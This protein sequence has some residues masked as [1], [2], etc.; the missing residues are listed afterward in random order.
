MPAHGIKYQ[1]E[2]GNYVWTRHRT[3]S[4]AALPSNHMKFEKI[5]S[6]M[7][8][9]KV[10]DSA[11]RCSRMEKGLRCTRAGALLSYIMHIA[12]CSRAH[13][14]WKG[15]DCEGIAKQRKACRTSDQR[16]QRDESVRYHGTKTI[17]R[18]NVDRMKA[19]LI[20]HQMIRSTRASRWEKEALV[21]RR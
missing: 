17:T 2:R 5:G 9:S 13:Y 19:Q 11:G 16:A 4:A 14:T 12:D 18:L 7:K 20:H 3:M 8:T 15:N 10:A 1:A 6:S 21:G